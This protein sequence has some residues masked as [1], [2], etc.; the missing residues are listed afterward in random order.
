MARLDLAVVSYFSPSD[1]AGGAETIAWSEAELLSRSRRVAFMSTSPP[2]QAPFDQLRLGAWTRRWSLIREDRSWIELA[3]FHLLSLFNPAVFLASLVVLARARPRIVHTHNLFALSPAIWLAARLTGAKVVHTHHDLWLLCERATMTNPDGTPCHEK[4]PTCRVCQWL[5]APKRGQ[6]ALVSAEIFPSSWLKSRLRRRG[7][8]IRSFTRL[9]SRS[10]APREGRIVYI[11]ALTPHKGVKILIEAFTKASGSSP[12]ALELVIAGAGPLAAAV[13]D[14]A[15]V[16]ANITY[17]GL[18]DADVRDN[19]LREASAVVIP[20]TWSEAS[21]VVF[22]EALAAG[23]PVI[24]SDIGSLSELATFGNTILVPPG[25]A[26]ALVD[27]I[28]QIAENGERTAQLRSA[29]R[30]NLQ[31]ASPERFRQ[32]VE[33]LLDRVSSEQ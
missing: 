19:L 22:F 3:V 10:S 29:A 31:V 26:D 18:V 7:A 8:I 25:D 30:R 5:R 32:E 2:V 14:A 12:V 23:L 16:T 27:A 4:T 33:E 6:L 21:P 17:V 11:G 24:A 1:F 9:F 13:A 15:R 28:R 20:S